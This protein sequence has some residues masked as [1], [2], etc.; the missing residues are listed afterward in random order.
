[1]PISELIIG[2]FRGVIPQNLTL[3]QW[4]Q[5]VRV[6]RYQQCLARF[7][8]RLQHLGVDITSLPEF[9]QNHFKNADIIANKQKHQVH[10]EAAELHKLLQ[11]YTAHLLFLKGA[12]YSLA[13]DA[14][15][16]FGR[17]YSDIDLL[18]DKSSLPA[19]EKE[20]ALYGF[21]AEDLDE[22]DQKYY[23]LWS[24]EIPPLRHGSR[25][26]VLDVHHNLLPLISGRAPDIN[27]FFAHTQTT[28]LGYTI[29]KPAA[30]FLHSTVHLF[31]NEEIKHGFRD[32]TDLSLLI[33][34]YQSEEF[35]Q[36]LVG[37]AVES[38]FATELCL[39]LRYTQKILGQEIPRSVLS[40][41]S[42]YTPAA[43]ALRYLDFIFLRVLRPI[44]PVFGDWNEQLAQFLLMVRGHYLKMPL[45]ILLKHMIWKG[46]RQITTALLGS[47]FLDKAEQK[48]Q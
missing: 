38:K 16:G 31:L 48:H 19:V 37:L 3:A 46:S 15:V 29:F 12:G 20:L 9:V 21:F 40:Q 27:V 18:V 1:M 17:T 45:P 24:H 28:E 41:L 36:E 14:Y 4:S 13:N 22:Y 35:W 34:Q 8:W 43:L 7:N 44:H 25:G 23:R 47:N 11:P 10:Y 26:T 39:A 30:M 32:L 42:P 33:E 5:I 6:L 2:I